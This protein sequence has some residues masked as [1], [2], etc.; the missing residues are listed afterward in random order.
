MADLG[1][2]VI[3]FFIDTKNA[4]KNS[5]DLNE[6]LGK[7]GATATK[8]SKESFQALANAIKPLKEHF[9]TIIKTVS[10]LEHGIVTV[11]GPL[12]T[13]IVR[14]SEAGVA[15]GLLSIA[16]GKIPVVGGAASAALKIL[17]V[18][19][20][21]ASAAATGLV[22][23]V[24]RLAESL[25]ERLHQISGSWAQ[26]AQQFQL[27][28]FE[29]AVATKLFNRTLGD[30]TLSA[31]QLNAQIRELSTTTGLSI[32]ALSQGTST[33]L[34]IGRSARFS[35]E[36]VEK[37]IKA[38]AEYSSKTGNDFE[39]VVQSIALSFN[40]LGIGARRVGLQL[41]D[42]AITN[43]ALQKGWEVTSQVAGQTALASLRVRAALEQMRIAGDQSTSSLNVTA[44]VLEF[45]TNEAN[46]F[47]ASLGEAVNKVMLPFQRAILGVI[48][49]LNALPAP[50][51]ASV[52]AIVEFSSRFFELI[53]FLIK[54]GTVAIAAVAAINLLKIAIGSFTTIVTA[55]S[56]A[57][58]RFTEVLITMGLRHNVFTTF[59]FLL[60]LLVKLQAAFLAVSTGSVTFATALSFTLRTAFVAL[61]ASIGPLLIILVPLIALFTA[62]GGLYHI[63][64]GASKELK[65]KFDLSTASIN[66]QRAALDAY[67]ESVKKS[68]EYN[69]SLAK[70]FDR[71]FV[72]DYPR[73]TTVLAAAIDRLSHESA[74]GKISSQLDIAERAA[75]R[76]GLIEQRVLKPTSSEFET[77]TAIENLT[78]EQ[79]AQFIE[80]PEIK[81]LRLR[82]QL[83][84][85]YIELLKS[86]S[87]YGVENRAKIQKGIKATIDSINLTLDQLNN[88][89]VP[90]QLAPLLKAAGIA[91]ETFPTL[92][93]E[94]KSLQESQAKNLLKTV[95]E[96][97]F[98]ANIDAIKN[99]Q[100]LAEKE[101]DI[102][103]ARQYQRL[104]TARQIA[105]LP[106]LRT[107]DTLRLLILT[108]QNDALQKQLGFLGQLGQQAQFLKPE[109]QKELLRQ[110]Q[111]AQAFITKR[112]T[113]G[114]VPFLERFQEVQK[115]QQDSG[116]AQQK[117]AVAEAQG[118]IEEAYKHRLEAELNA[119][120]LQN[121]TKDEIT[122]AK[123]RKDEAFEGEQAQRRAAV[124]EAT[125]SAEEA[126]QKRLTAEL[127]ALRQQQ[128]ASEDEI[129]KVRARKIAEFNYQRTQAI[130]D[131]AA[132]R[133][134]AEQQARETIIGVTTGPTEQTIQ[135]ESE[136]R[137][138]QLRIDLTKQLKSIEDS[139][140]DVAEKIAQAIM[141]FNAQV[142]ASEVDAYN[143]R[144]QLAT[145]YYQQV[146]ESAKGVLQAAEEF[147]QKYYTVSRQPFMAQLANLETQ[148]AAFKQELD[149]RITNINNMQ[150]DAT[151]KEKLISDAVATESLKRQ[152]TYLDEQK[153]RRDA[154][155]ESYRL[156]IDLDAKLKAQ[157]RRPEDIKD[158]EEDL[159]AAIA[160]R[161]ISKEKQRQR[162]IRGARR[163]LEDIKG[164]GRGVE[165]AL[166]AENINDTSDFLNDAQ[167]AA[168][169]QR[170]QASGFVEQLRTRLQQ[171]TAVFGKT[172]DELNDRVKQLTDHLPSTSSALQSLTEAAVAAAAALG[173][174]RSANSGKP[175]PSPDGEI[176]FMPEEATPGG[177]RA[178]QKITGSSII[179]DRFLPS[180]QEGGVVEETGPA[181]LH[182]NEF[183]IPSAAGF[184]DPQSKTVFKSS[185]HQDAYHANMKSLMDYTAD[186]QSKIQMSG[187]GPP[188]LWSQNEKG[189]LGGAAYNSAGG[190]PTL[191]SIGAG[192]PPKLPSDV[193]SSIVT[194]LLLKSLVPEEQQKGKS[195]KGKKSG[196]SLTIG[197]ALSMLGIT[198]DLPEG[199]ADRKIP[200]YQSG[201]FPVPQT[202]LALVHEGETILPRQG[203]LAID[204]TALGDNPLSIW[205]YLLGTGNRPFIQSPQDY[206]K[207]YNQQQRNFSTARSLNAFSSMLSQNFTSTGQRDRAFA[208][209]DRLAK[210]LLRHGKM[211][212][213]EEGTPYVSENMIAQLHK[214]EAVIP[215]NQNY[216]SQAMAPSAPRVS[217]HGM[218]SEIMN[219]PKVMQS[220]ADRM[221]ASMKAASTQMVDH[222][223]HQSSVIP[224]K[225]MSIVKERLPKELVDEGR[226][227]GRGIYG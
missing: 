69:V 107:E 52:G 13:F 174:I 37:L 55:A 217:M 134:A 32:P 156:E 222:M 129:A 194:S 126:F 96:P 71:I 89:K 97:T 114:L 53:G 22:F 36:Q 171:M 9:E 138:I 219:L 31:A 201:A 165:E 216:M 115:L 116:I 139:R 150:I 226:R 91:G 103:K 11:L 130:I 148:R 141:Q 64:T 2:R 61:I 24:G 169:G 75:I 5:Q 136:F 152:G 82:I 157:K 133:T 45:V 200:S 68:S 185:G 160:G 106:G 224:H 16:V 227:A 123:A 199:L 84:E 3:E 27:F 131:A 48:Q 23:A 132:A 121:A 76:H 85:K 176:S 74:I 26:V 128:Y 7:L 44:K 70:T 39:R 112:D 1:K 95:T 182:K 180:Y 6:M 67:S 87:Y 192:G 12:G 202:S 88:K 172:M 20:L 18:A 215:A 135:F 137:Q 204:T 179:G 34:E 111:Q 220:A 124:L 56:A 189:I 47:K 100:I 43:L 198:T 211:Q 154:M 90:D 149:E 25:G 35:S 42:L 163:R 168:S 113:P 184:F 158:A 15:L 188:A 191:E 73:V 197:E 81:S 80:S 187:A 225:V 41:D 28:Q 153:L 14:S 50:L 119:L 162:N 147:T 122:R 30:T 92:G 63:M 140:L 33:L 206:L 62:L 181:L 207:A 94:P 146:L 186:L 46:N 40:G 167:R 159:Q 164:T 221:V 19:L 210:Q 105:E 205:Q 72:R 178:K 108:D 183:V 57:G 98:A 208:Q 93:V 117:A 79:R 78:K 83:E 118:F 77:N 145:Q 223:D 212:G 196:T 8:L 142:L 143:K 213:F 151:Q 4:I 193:T 59:P 49:A 51:K 120:R 54:W 218:S 209:H 65:D 175:V 17:A 170:P 166:A 104:L 203:G 58:L 29:V 99:A 155:L 60:D 190:P 177:T 102:V 173:S 125:G 66:N 214:G 127:I 21:G 144:K 101:G 10:Q 86:E 195:K 38:S 109:Q 110:Q 161:P